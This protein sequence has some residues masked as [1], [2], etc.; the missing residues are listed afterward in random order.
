[1]AEIKHYP[2]LQSFRFAFTGITEAIKAERNFK[3]HLVMALLAVLLGLIVGLT[4]IEWA[5]IVLV[6]FV[7]LAA[8]LFNSA[9]EGICNLLREENNLDYEKT[10]L[11]RDIS[12][13]TTLLLAIAS[14]IIA[15]FVYLPYF[16]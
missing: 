5:I 9:I 15:I 12:A 7:I 2:L 13:G 10:R 1:M 3:I 14:V 6:I 11:V 8:E 4:R 16:L